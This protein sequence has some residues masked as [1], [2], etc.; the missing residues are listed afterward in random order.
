MRNAVW[1][2]L[3]NLLIV[4]PAAAAS[5]AGYH[6]ARTPA[7]LALDRIVSGVL[8]GTIFVPGFQKQVYPESQP[9]T[10]TMTARMIDQI[11]REEPAV[12]KACKPKGGC[13][14]RYYPVSCR[15]DGADPV[16]RTEEASAD[17][18]VVSFK[19]LD[20]VGA[21]EEPPKVGDYTLIKVDGAWKLDHVR[22][23]GGP[24]AEQ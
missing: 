13:M 7:E 4:G 12:V 11:V 6:P 8:N 16:Y 24:L 1:F 10:A 5:P 18:V 22:C 23:N 19:W 2:Y 9:A 17:K 20:T 21:F 3:A 15:F 14:W